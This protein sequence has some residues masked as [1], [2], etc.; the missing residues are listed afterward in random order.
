MTD[1]VAELSKMF[2]KN[3]YYYYFL[4]E[5]KWKDKDKDKLIFKY[6]LF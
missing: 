6:F 3:L 1:T 4:L 2:T 5:I